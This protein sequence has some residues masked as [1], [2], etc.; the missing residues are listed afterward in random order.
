MNWDAL[1]ALGELVG[2]AA[3]VATLIYLSVQLRQNTRAVKLSSAQAVTEELQ[4]MFSLLSSDQSLA[5][6][7]VEAGK[8]DELSGA[9]LV[10]YYTFNSNL[11]RVYENAFLQKQE[12][13]IN[14]AHWI[15]MT[16]MMIDYSKMAAFS[17]YWRDRKHWLSDEFQDHMEAEII[18]AA[19][20]PGI[21]LPGN[22]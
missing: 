8:S 7:F 21:N 16:R 19:Q 14:N 11:L 2:A 1:G 9:D 17:S 3:V 6:I 5:E 13:A 18:S 20:K 10:R 12:N 22:Y 4:A 15:G